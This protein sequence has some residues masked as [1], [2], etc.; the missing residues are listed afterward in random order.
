MSTA[1]NYRQ[2][3]RS[4]EGIKSRQFDSEKAFYEFLEQIYNEIKQK[5]NELGQEQDSLGIFICSIGLFAFG[6]L[7]V[8]EDILDHVP[9]KK[10]PANHLAGVIPNLLPL[11]QKLSWRENPESLRAWIR[12]N[13]THLK[14]DEISE[15]YVLQE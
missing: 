7:D 11:P 4:L 9:H 2:S 1:N 14:W 15:I 13:F 12:E 10:Y 3:I 8:V 5:Y 6:R